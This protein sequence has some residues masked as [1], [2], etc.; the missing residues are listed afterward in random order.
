MAWPPNGSGHTFTPACSSSP[1]ERDKDQPTEEERRGERDVHAQ[2]LVPGRQEEGSTRNTEQ[3]HDSEPSTDTEVDQPLPRAP[4][5]Q[6]TRR[7]VPGLLT[8]QGHTSSSSTV[9]THGA[10]PPRRST[11]L[12]PP[13]SGALRAWPSRACWHRQANLA[14]RPR[15]PR[16]AGLAAAFSQVVPHPAVHTVGARVTVERLAA[17]AFVV[18][19]VV[20]DASMMGIGDGELAD[21]P[22]VASRLPEDWMTTPRASFGHYPQGNLD[23]VLASVQALND[24]GVDILVGTD[25]SFPLPFLGRLAHW[26]SVHHELQYLVRAGLTPVQALRA[27]TSTPARR[28]S[29]GDRSGGN[30]RA[31]VEGVAGTGRVITAAAAILVAVFAAFV[32]SPEVFLKGLRLG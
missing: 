23:D 26:A 16:G 6:Q 1:G 29:L 15:L 7:Q 28:F 21:D 27:A 18:P 22:R 9:R 25:A 5:G 3:G 12:Q 19:C 20:L 11:P 8:R 2:L 4:T 17:G 32:P 24:A 30:S 31:V 13:S 14:S 10:R